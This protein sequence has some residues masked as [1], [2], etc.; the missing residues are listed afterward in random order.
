LA[1]QR[2]AGHVDRVSGYY[3]V[4]LAWW[5]GLVSGGLLF[6]TC[7]LTLGWRA[8]GD[9][10]SVSEVKLFPAPG[11]ALGLVPE[12]PNVASKVEGW[13]D[14]YLVEQQPRVLVRLVARLRGVK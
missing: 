9:A 2:P 14:D 4:R 13:V 8:G 1:P 10:R 5:V 6:S 12:E 11:D 3:V 7:F